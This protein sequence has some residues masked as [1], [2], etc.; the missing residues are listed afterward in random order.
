[1]TH[2]HHAQTAQLLG[3]VEY[4]RRETRRHLTV[5]THF[6]TSLNLVFALYKTVQH[7]FCIDNC[8]TEIGH[9]GNQCRIPLVGDLGECR[10]TR[11]HENLTDM[12]F[13][14]FTIFVSH[15]KEG[16]GCLFFCRFVLQRPNTISSLDSL[17]SRHSDLGE[18]T[19]FKT[20]HIKEEIEMRMD[21][22]G[23]MEEG[24]LVSFQEVGGE[25]WTE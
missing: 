20:T 6:N 24:T 18:N 8:F 12:I 19:N 25:P 9:E 11:R 4:D 1:M 21:Y 22:V 7:F 15:T 14:S 10:T 5:Q 17:L 23:V 13:K 16:S 3:C 2:R